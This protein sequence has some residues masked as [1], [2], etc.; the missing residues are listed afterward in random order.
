[1]RNT[2]LAISQECRRAGD[3][4]AARRGPRATCSWRARVRPA[5]ARAAMTQLIVLTPIGVVHGGRSQFCE[6]HSPRRS[7]GRRRRAPCSGSH[8]ASAKYSG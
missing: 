4:A 5:P 6:D 3:S 1:M 2:E 8:R 7:T